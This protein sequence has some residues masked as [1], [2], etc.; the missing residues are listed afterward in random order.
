MIKKCNSLLIMVAMVFGTMLTVNAQGDN[1]YQMWESITLTPDNSKLKVLAVNMR[2]HNQTYHKSGAHKATVFN[3]TTGPNTGKIVWEMGPLTYSDL[4][5]R[6]SVGGHD[7]D[8][9]DNIMPYIKKINTAEYWKE[10]AKRSNTSMLDGDNSKYPILH[11]RYHEV[12]PGHGYTINRL[13]SQIK[14]TLESIDGVYPWG[15]YTNEFQQGDLGR[16]IA[17]VSFGKNWAEYDQDIK[18][19]EAFEKI[20]GKNSYNTYVDMRNDTFKNRWDEVWVYD[21]NMSGD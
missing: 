16:H 1:S 21:K 10:D 11:I 3:I 4:D 8:W 15:V 9:R 7:E 12:N 14:A 13:F 20:Y 6:P 5:K 2:K 17:T 18:F 19:V